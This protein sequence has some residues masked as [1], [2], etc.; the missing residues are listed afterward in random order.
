MSTIH[1]RS[2]LER[3]LEQVKQNILRLGSRVEQAINR[4]V[5]ALKERDD[6][7]AQQV[8]ND[9]E[10]INALRYEIE[11]LCLQAIA[12]QQPAAGDLRAIIAGMHIA[13][14]LERMADHAE[15][16]AHLTLRMVD[17]PLLKPL[18]DIPR[19]AEI[20]QEMIGT[21]L[22]AYIKGDAGLAQQVAARDDELDVLHNQ[23]FRE[24]I[25]YMIEDP[26]NIGRAT[27]LLWVAHNLE[28]IGDRVTNICERVV[29][30]TTGQL[31]EIK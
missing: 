24:L 27:F 16:I 19:M 7:L 23:I 21:A 30:M 17:Q 14:E 8:I 22:D 31:K 1:I 29:F 25:T 26:K 28:R 11:E 15:G 6:H 5:R 13:G 10:S 18:L 9:D 20:C 3:E 12:T 4:S 2:A